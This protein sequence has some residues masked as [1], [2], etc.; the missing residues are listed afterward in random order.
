MAFQ[1]AVWVVGKM[2]VD[3]KVSP[4]TFQVGR[5]DGESER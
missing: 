4:K 5:W 1:G 3:L 2:I